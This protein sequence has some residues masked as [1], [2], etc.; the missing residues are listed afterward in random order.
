MC[1]DRVLGHQLRVG[2]NASTAAPEVRALLADNV[3]EGLGEEEGDGEG[4]EEAEEGEVKET[5]TWA[6]GQLDGCAGGKVAE[7]ENR[8][9]DD[10]NWCADG[11]HHECACWHTRRR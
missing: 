3:F 10:D 4:G 1:I 11:E 8:D 6:V 7:K 5:A 2:Y 9:G